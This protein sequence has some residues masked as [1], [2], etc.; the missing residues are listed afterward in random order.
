MSLDY[1]WQI[2]SI[3]CQG[4]P[5]NSTTAK[6]GYG[7]HASA[8]DDIQELLASFWTQETIQSSSTVIL[9]PDE[10]E[11]EHHFATTQARDSS[12]RYVVRLPLKQSIEQL[13]DSSTAAKRCLQS[14]L[15]RLSSNATLSSLCYNFMT[16][17]PHFYLPYHGVL[18]EH[19]T[20]T[21][22]RA[23]FNGSCNT[24]AGASLN[25]V[26]HPGP[27]IQ[28]DLSDVR[29]WIR[30]HRYVFATDITNMFR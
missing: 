18:K 27:K 14:M 12:G 7:Y 5:T 4:P 8:D 29:L 21:K 26:L 16:S 19:S 22:L 30:R 25:D 13:R 24:S 3:F 20:T 17:K 10:A 28:I 2:Q 1:S 15:R 11:C 6:G 23:V 9:S